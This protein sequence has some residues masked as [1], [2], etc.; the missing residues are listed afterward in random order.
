MKILKS[1]SW[2]SSFPLNPFKGK[3]EKIKIVDGKRRIL[4]LGKFHVSLWTIMNTYVWIR[5]V[6]RRTD[7]N[8]SNDLEFHKKTDLASQGIRVKADEL[9]PSNLLLTCIDVVSLVVFLNF[10]M[11]DVARFLHFLFIGNSV[12]K[13]NNFEQLKKSIS[14][15]K[16][17][18]IT[19]L[20]D[21]IQNTPWYDELKIL[22]DKPI[23]HHRN[24]TSG[25]G[26]IGN[27]IGI[28]LQYVQNQKILGKFISN[29]EIDRFSNN[30]YHFLID[31]NEYLCDNF[32]YLPLE[33]Q[34][35]KEINRQIVKGIICPFCEDEMKAHKLTSQS[36]E[37]ITFSCGKCEAVGSIQRKN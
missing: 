16:G 33:V 2:W 26:L 3:I 28:H 17:T 18:K 30:V 25:I 34:K 24:L 7:D 10:L 36:K 27:E 32:D 8:F 5:E 29:L 35:K 19:K 6:L 11:D 9:P 20:I 4:I 14:S 12:P 21:I 15:F 31:L 23:V 13:T 1:E 37:K 22:R